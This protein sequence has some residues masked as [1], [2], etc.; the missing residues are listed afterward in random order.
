MTKFSQDDGVEDKLSDTV[1]ELAKKFIQPEAEKV[2]TL[3]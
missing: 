2:I 1:G 3:S